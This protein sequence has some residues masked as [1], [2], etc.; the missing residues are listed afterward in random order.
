MKKSTLYKVHRGL[1]VLVL[2][3]VLLWCFSGLLHP[4]MSNW[5]RIQPAHRSAPKTTTAK[6]DI[7]ISIDSLLKKQQ[8]KN[9]A[10]LGLIHFND[11]SYYQVKQDGTIRYYD[12]NVGAALKE[13]DTVYAKYLA[14]YY[15]G[16]DKAKVKQIELLEDFTDEYKSINRYLPIYKVSY[17]SSMDVYVHTVTGKLGTMNNRIKKG[18]LWCFS[19]FHNWNFLGHQP[20]LKP[21]VIFVFSVCTFITGLLGLWIAFMNRSKYKKRKKGIEKLKKRNFHRKWSVVVSLFLL[22]FSFS[23]AY[24]AISKYDYS[25]SGYSN[26]VNHYSS[27]E[28]N[29][30]IRTVLPEDTQ[31]QKMALATIEG[32]LYYNISIKGMKSPQ[33][34]HTQTLTLL[35]NGLHQ[36]ATSLAKQQRS[37]FE[38]KQV[39]NIYKFA[40]EYG[41]INKRLPVVKVSANTDDHLT[42]YIDTFEEVIASKIDDSRRKEAFSFLML[43]KFHFLDKPI[44]KKNRDIVIALA[45]LSILGILFS[46]FSVFLSTRTKNK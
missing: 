33:Y 16:D 3:P 28:F 24:H 41:F 35:K 7:Q 21:I 18:Y 32:A 6:N 17:N 30:D 27:D 31:I 26:H 9:V 12:T 15:L 1:S 19:M 36:H 2:I 39:E 4:V 5:F 40:H 13:G 37:N 45:I 22:M 46:G 14:N 25:P 44:G 20:R 10:Q 23:G 43:H 11:Q 29:T 8:I 34:Y 38:L 42:Y